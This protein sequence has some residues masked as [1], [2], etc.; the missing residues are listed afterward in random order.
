MKVCVFGSSSSNLDQIY[1]DAAEELGHV[2]AER[3]HALVFGGYD[4]G[5]MGAVARGVAA[6]GGEVYGV[7]TEGLSAKGD[8]DVF[9]CTHVLSCADL[10]QRKLAMV[11]MA[12]AFVTLPGGIG[13][14]DELFDVLSQ[15]KAGEACKGCA[16]YNVAGYFNPLVTMLDEACEKGLNSTDWHDYCAVFD[17][18]EELVV[19]LEH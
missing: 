16:I 19:Y 8:R 12:D 9:A 11:A 10:A 4:M 17:N 2:L 3:D 7:V 15:A 6:G 14:F 1:S 5:L 13:T 18:A